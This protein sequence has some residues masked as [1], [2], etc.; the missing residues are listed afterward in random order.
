M[1]LEM[2]HRTSHLKSITL[3]ASP[4]LTASGLPKDE[5]FTQKDKSTKTA[6]QK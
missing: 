4:L 2:E 5:K 6:K 1:R 3:H